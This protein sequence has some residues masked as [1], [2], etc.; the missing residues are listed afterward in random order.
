MEELARVYAESLFGVAKENGSVDAVREQLAQLTEAL[1]GS[2]EL[3]VF[4]FSPYFS[5][6]EKLDGLHRAVTDADPRLLNFL[7]LLIEKHRM[8]AIFRIRQ[9]FE[10]LWK[11]E[12]RML[13]VTVTSAVELDPAVAREVGAEV[14]R[15]TGKSVELNSRVDES[16]IG[17]LVLQV[18]N[19]VL[20][21]SIRNNLEKLRQSVARAG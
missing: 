21:T 11:E 17:G 5:S 20:D 2:R 13:E 9:R 10:E 7:E 19:M 1:E 6:Q 16:I 3:E 15:Q 14:E 4:F 12:N 8:P 18:G